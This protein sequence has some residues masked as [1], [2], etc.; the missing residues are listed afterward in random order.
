MD[1]L[2]LLVK[3]RG[4]E[5][6]FVALPFAR[7]PRRIHQRSVLFVYGPGLAME[8]GLI[9]VGIQHLHFISL[10]QEHAAVAALLTFAF[11]YRRCGPFDVQLAVAEF[12]PG[13]YV[14]SPRDNFDITVCDL[15]FGIAGT[16]DASPFY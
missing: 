5:Y 6:D 13:G 11:D 12:F 10:H 14:T 1:D 9:I 2:A 8:V 7:F 16:A 15:P 4:L 3:L